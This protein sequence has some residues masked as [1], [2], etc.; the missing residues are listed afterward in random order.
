ME[1][2]NALDTGAELWGL[3]SSFHSPREEKKAER[4]MLEDLSKE[5][6][7]S[8]PDISILRNSESP[9]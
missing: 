8:Y 7:T 1:Y 2:Y 3:N 9:N 5:S 4:N 6:E